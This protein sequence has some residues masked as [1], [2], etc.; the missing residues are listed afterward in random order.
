MCLSYGP[1][2]LTAFSDLQQSQQQLSNSSTHQ[3]MEHYPSWS[4]DTDTSH[5]SGDT[6]RQE[7]QQRHSLPLTRL[8]Q[9]PEVGGAHHVRYSIVVIPLEKAKSQN[10]N[11]KP[12]A[13][14][15]VGSLVWMYSPASCDVI[16]VIDYRGNN[17]SLYLD[18]FIV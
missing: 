8:S 5:G 10:I 18:T 13:F 14:S 17:Q 6:L 1:P 7:Q 9:T 16:T 15:P 11:I 2:D 3:S 12:E 4:N